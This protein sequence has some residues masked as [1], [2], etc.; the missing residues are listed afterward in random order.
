MSLR[1]ANV[2]S[3]HKAV[4]PEN[5]AAFTNVKKASE[6]EQPVAR[7]VSEIADNEAPF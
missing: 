7:D 5:A 3:V 4:A 1:Y 6:I 2:G